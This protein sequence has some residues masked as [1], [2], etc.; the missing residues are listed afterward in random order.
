MTKGRSLA[1]V[2]AALLLAGTAAGADGSLILA[3]RGRAADCAIIVPQA[4][5]ETVRYAAEEQ[6]GRAHV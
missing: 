4:A 6:I 3:E 2:V 5:D 1:F